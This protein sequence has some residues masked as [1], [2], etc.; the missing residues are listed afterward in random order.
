MTTSIQELTEHVSQLYVDPSSPFNK[1]I[2]P[3]EDEEINEYVLPERPVED[4]DVETE[5]FSIYSTPS[6]PGHRNG[7][8]FATAKKWLFSWLKTNNSF[9]CSITL[10]PIAKNRVVQVAHIMLP[11]SAKPEAVSPLVCNILTNS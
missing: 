6:A 9:R 5:T 1:G 8:T 3:F 2:Q 4:V 7:T 10:T 11:Q